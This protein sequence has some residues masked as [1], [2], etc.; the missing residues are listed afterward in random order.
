MKTSTRKARIL[1]PLVSG[2]F[3]ACIFVGIASGA[4]AGPAGRTAAGGKDVADD[5]RN[6]I[7]A[8][9]QLLKTGAG[10]RADAADR[11][12]AF[13]WDGGNGFAQAWDASD[14]GL[15]QADTKKL[16]EKFVDGVFKKGTALD[17]REAEAL[18]P[19]GLPAAEAKDAAAL[20]YI[21]GAGS[22]VDSA[23]VKPEVKKLFQEN[24]SFRSQLKSELVACLG[25]YAKA[26]K[27]G[28]GSLCHPA[29]APKPLKPLSAEWVKGL[30]VESAVTGF[31]LYD[32]AKQ[33]SERAKAPRA[34][35][36]GKEPGGVPAGDGKPTER[37]VRGT[38][39]SK[40]FEVADMFGTWGD[41]NVIHMPSREAK[42]GE[43]PQDIPGRTLAVV[44][45]TVRTFEGDPA[46]PRPKLKHQIGV[47]DISNASDIYGKRFDI[48]ADGQSTFSLKDGG[49]EYVLKFT[50]NGADTSVSLERSD[51][52]KP[53]YGAAGQAELP[54][55]NG[56]FKNRAQ[57][58]LETGNLVEVGGQRYIVSGESAGRGYLCFWPEK[59]LQEGVGAADPRTLVP[60]MVAYTNK[61]ADGRIE[62]LGDQV[63]LGKVDGKW[64]ELKWNAEQGF[65]EPVEGKPPAVD[66]LPA[67]GPRQGN[68]PQQGDQP[69]QPGTSEWPDFEHPQLGVRL[70]V[71]ND[72][73]KAVN[74]ELAAAKLKA[75]VYSCNPRQK[76]LDQYF[77]AAKSGD[78]VPNIR[79]PFV[80]GG[81]SDFLGFQLLGGSVL[82]IRDAAGTLY[83][84]IRRAPESFT[85]RWF[86]MGKKSNFSVGGS[87]AALKDAMAR[88][89]LAKQA[90]T[91]WK[92]VAG[93]GTPVIIYS[94]EGSKLIQAEYD[95][96]KVREVWPKD[97][98]VSGARP[99]DGDVPGSGHALDPENL[100][101]GSQNGELPDQILDK[102]T[103]VLQK[104]DGAA[105]YQVRASDAKTEWYMILT[106]KDKAGAVKRYGPKL[107]FQDPADTKAKFPGKES[108]HIRGL[109]LAGASPEDGELKW[110]PR[111]DGRAALEQKGFYAVWHGEK[112]GK[113]GNC[114]GVTAYWGMTLQKAEALCKKKQ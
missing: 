106:I 26:G 51:G 42:P 41:V 78:Q 31:R 37:K 92:R 82:A 81:Q 104:M 58:A 110:G 65:W 100:G 112:S 107:V 48:V 83:F 71:N 87:E 98:P 14:R 67:G 54:S 109:A 13:M 44:V 29:V 84:D 50:P 56:L 60:E 88:A 33:N 12:D 93:H 86:W 75:R 49:A 91:V 77:L 59:M 18:K 114:L 45:R 79:V 15:S 1:S 34:D 17:P 66:T 10:W 89:G 68:Q 73:V 11:I 101:G 21:L 8:I 108:I 9:A 53:V 69:Q 20:Y 16:V 70:S 40:V 80:G 47:Y 25:R 90:D 95:D 105:L 5:E 74:Q 22:I 63:S 61:K 6:E 3:I 7:N 113:W 4:A 38:D 39:L 64:W 62:R 97:Q 24:K 103:E 19:L 2:L 23:Q 72:D 96:G 27:P 55:V 111:Q 43:K 85:D 52:I 94:N 102:P 99:G 36:D 30:C 32:A 35:G 28:A 57:K 46:D 76:L